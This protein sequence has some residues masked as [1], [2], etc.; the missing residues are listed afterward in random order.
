MKNMGFR[1]VLGLA[2][3]GLLWAAGCARTSRQGHPPENLSSRNARFVQD[4]FVISFWVHPPVDDRIEERYREIADAGFNV[5]LGGPPAARETTP[6]LDLCKKLGLKAIVPV[7][8]GKMKN[9]APDHPALWGYL[10]KDEPATAEFEDLARDAAQVRRLRPGKLMFVNLFPNYASPG[11]LG[12]STYEEY[13]RRFVEEVKPD[14]LCMDHYPRFR[15]GQ[16]DGRNA[17]CKN[18][19]VMRDES[20]RVGI[21]F[22]NFFNTM[23]YGD[24][25]DPTEA[26]LRW[27]VYAS[28]AHGA[29]GVL[30]FCYYTPGGGEFPKGGAIIARD[31][32]RTRHYDQARRLNAELA[33]LGPTLMK[34]TSTRV[35]RIKPRDDATS[36]LAGGPIRNLARSPEDPG[37]NYLVGEFLHADGR[38]AVF[39]QNYHFAYTA[40]PTVEFDAPPE[41]V[42]EIDKGSGREIPVRDESPNL[43]GLQIP[44]DAGEGRLFLLP[45]SKVAQ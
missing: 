40:W 34:L 32:R 17:Y 10:W 2:G 39:L 28:V 26:Q 9:L 45:P 14:V 42:V 12:A 31:G 13:V 11:Q 18:L 27:Q 22:W 20:L 1:F 37:P 16:K 33:C 15:P 6:Q 35:V 19:A 21:P 5:V 23:P 25:T 41:Q 8:Q 3:L 38:R 44:L 43:E 24:Q 7:P 4:R 36:I 29:K 30:Y